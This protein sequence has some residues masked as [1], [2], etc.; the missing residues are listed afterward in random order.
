MS[1]K[2]YKTIVVLLGFSLLSILGLQGMWINNFYKQKQEEFSR[3]VYAC[4]T[5]ISEKLNER[6]NIHVIKE[7]YSQDT[8]ITGENE[9]VIKIL[10]S[11]T[12]MKEPVHVNFS[13]NLRKP[14]K[15]RGKKI[16]VSDSVVHINSNQKTIVVSKSYEGGT[17]KEDIQKLMDKM[18]LEIKTLDVSPIEKITT[19]TL[20][21]IIK[22]ELNNKGIF[23]PYDFCLKKGLGTKEKVLVRSNFFNESRPVIKGDL[24]SSRIF[25]NHD[26]LMIQ[27]PSQSSFVFAGMKNILALSALF[28]LLITF[29]FFYTMRTILKQKKLAEMK[30]DFINNMTHEL[31]TPIAT[32][33]LAIDAINNPLVKE[34]RD[35]FT[36]YSNILKEENKKLNRHVERV[37]EMALLDKGRMQLNK[38]TF[39]LNSV[40]TSAISSF[41][42]QL[43]DKN[44]QLLF[45][46]NEPIIINADEQHLRS[47]FEN[48]LDN[49]LKYSRENCHITIQIQKSN[50]T[51]SVHFKDDGIGIDKNKQQ[52]IFDKFY[53]AQGGNLHDVKG[54][55]LGLSYVKSIMEAHGGTVDLKSE[56]GK[57]SEF[58]LKFHHA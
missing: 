31:K 29:V 55:G 21:S 32:I 40:I 54:F 18:M 45:E 47:V 48:L 14:L 56:I 27:F 33:S 20:D 26:Y 44:A 4:L 28:S 11:K 43:H 25:G 24:S 22:K 3:T 6:E 38:K 10:S 7:S 9:E 8:I 30:N 41:E 19:R 57:G 12:K 34:D 39:D 42:L 53:R 23:I 2:A 51:V 1:S 36:N 37:L 49:A 5:H 58:I 17:S 16:I 50:E 35:R 13:Y 46:T 52:K 15:I